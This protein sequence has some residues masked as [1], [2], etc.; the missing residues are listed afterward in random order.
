MGNRIQTREC[1][2][3]G[4]R[5]D[6]LYHHR[7]GWSALERED[8]DDLRCPACDGSEFV[9]I[10][11]AASGI[12]LGGSAGVGKHFPYYDRALGCEVTSHQH[13]T[14]LMTHHPNGTRRADRLLPTEGAVDFVAEAEKEFAAR[15]RREA[16][17]QEMI[18][19]YEGDPEL[20]EAYGRWKESMRGDR[21]RFHVDRRSSDELYAETRRRTTY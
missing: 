6:V 19:S 12:Q 15:D 18:A 13:R 2:A 20:R 4:R 10:I 7:E 5:Y 14:W 3:C 9:P 17:Y 11:G 8:L 16:G 1:A 21:D